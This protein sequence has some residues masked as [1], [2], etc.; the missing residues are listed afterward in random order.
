MDDVTLSSSFLTSMLM[1]QHKAVGMAVSDST[2][3][4]VAGSS[5]VI[6]LLS[7]VLSIL[8]MGTMP[9]TK[10]WTNY[11]VCVCV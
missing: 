1:R 10:Y 7:L 11:A 6:T 8:E 5:G 4:T 2:W 9:R 3:Q